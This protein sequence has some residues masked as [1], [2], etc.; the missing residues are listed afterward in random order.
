M[1]AVTTCQEGFRCVSRV[2]RFG[3]EHVYEV[4]R[5][6]A[7]L[8]QSMNKASSAE[9]ED[10]G[11]QQPKKEEPS[12][13]E[14]EW[15]CPV[16]GRWEQDRF[17]TGE[18]FE[19]CREAKDCICIARGSEDNY[20]ELNN[21]L[22]K[23]HE[24]VEAEIGCGGGKTHK[25]PIVVTPHYPIRRVPESFDPD[26]INADMGEIEELPADMWVETYKI[27]APKIQAALDSLRTYINETYS[28][29]VAD[30]PF[31]CGAN[32]PG[33]LPSMTP[34][35]V[36][37]A[38]IKIRRFQI[39]QQ[40]CANMRDTVPYLVSPT[41]ET[42]NPPGHQFLSVK[43]KLNC[44]KAKGGDTCLQLN[45]YSGIEDSI[46]RDRLREYEAKMMACEP[47][48]EDKPGSLAQEA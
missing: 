45:C 12:V 23:R 11:Q 7:K 14:Y 24:T 18:E 4:S 43:T 33:Q 10:G 20:V 42:H 6:N 32:I 21:G 41:N 9:S 26:N 17:E 44:Y 2:G 31:V 38:S 15:N 36:H 13:N 16:K 29:K 39:L 1:A 8:A 46:F 19:Q 5:E 25:I 37:E 30:K 35:E 40:D 22:E 34:D 27:N 48:P 3:S 28:E 47:D